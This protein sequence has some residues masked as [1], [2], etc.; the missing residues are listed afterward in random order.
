MKTVNLLK[1]KLNLLY[2]LVNIR[3]FILSIL[4]QY[5][6]DGPYDKKQTYKTENYPRFK[7]YFPYHLYRD[8]I[9]IFLISVQNDNDH[10]STSAGVWQELG[11]NIKL[12]TIESDIIECNS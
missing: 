7:D 6:K 1:K 11:I 12:C 10:L 5:R 2:R 3:K 9:K 8:L 4:K